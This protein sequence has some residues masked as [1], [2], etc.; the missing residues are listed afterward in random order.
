MSCGALSCCQAGACGFRHDSTG[1]VSHVS[2]LHARAVAQLA[3]KCGGHCRRV[4]LLV[5][6][7]AVMHL[8]DSSAEEKVRQKKKLNANMPAEAAKKISFREAG[9][10][11]CCGSSEFRVLPKMGGWVWSLGVGGVRVPYSYTLRSRSL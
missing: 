7:H 11:K 3:L 5:Q 10:Q 8:R 6:G 1:H 9:Q 2:V 4:L